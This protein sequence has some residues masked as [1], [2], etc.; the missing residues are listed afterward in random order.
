LSLILNF[1]FNYFFIIFYFEF[2]FFVFFSFLQG[3]A[4]WL[5]SDKTKQYDMFQYFINISDAD[6]EKYLKLFTFFKIE[7]I[8]EIVKKH[9]EKPEQRIAQT[10][11]AETIVKM[12]YFE[13]NKQNE[14]NEDSSQTIAKK[15]FE[16][17]FT[18]FVKIIHLLMIFIKFIIK[19]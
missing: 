7:T 11:L 18:H 17:D 2:Q 15:F 16:T 8:S 12:L 3:N 14:N 13:E 10:V 1:I 4:I 5:T 9:K 6:V 19:H